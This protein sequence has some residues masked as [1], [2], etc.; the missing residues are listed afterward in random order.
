LDYQWYKP[1]PYDEPVEQGD[2]ILKCPVPIIKEKEEFPFFKLGGGIYDVIVMTQA[3]DLVNDKVEDVTLCALMPLSEVIEG[4]ML[5]D[6]N[7]EVKKNFNYNSLTGS[8]RKK[9][10]SIIQKL[11]SGSYLDFHVIN[12]FNDPQK[13]L[14]K[15]DYMVV[16]LRQTYTLPKKALGKILI[17]KREERIRLLPPYREHVAQ[18]FARNFFR[19]GLPIDLNINPESV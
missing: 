17:Q 7:D 1:V 16:L 4:L 18:S 12:E 8:Q 9:K 6:L 13:P 14:L 10:N 15:M 5:K 19:I 3:C 2:I 11:K